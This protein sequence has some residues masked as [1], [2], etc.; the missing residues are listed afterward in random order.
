MRMSM[1]V[2]VVNVLSV[3]EQ[4]P[5]VLA[6][7]PQARV[8]VAPTILLLEQGLSLELLDLAREQAGVLLGGRRQSRFV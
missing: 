1:P 7:R 6:V 2:S 5:G 8:S 3:Q 4:A